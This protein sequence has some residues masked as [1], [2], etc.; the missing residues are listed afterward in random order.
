MPQL[1][2]I[3]LL[4]KYVVTGQDYITYCTPLEQNVKKNESKKHFF[5][6]YIFGCCFLMADST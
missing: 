1:K 5:F 6:F 3:V 4:L 2:C